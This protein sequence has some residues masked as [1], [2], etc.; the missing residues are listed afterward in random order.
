MLGPIKLNISSLAF[1]CWSPDGIAGN[2]RTARAQAHDS[3]LLPD[4]AIATMMVIIFIRRSSNC[5]QALSM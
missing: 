1:A 4:L 2:Q 5:Y 3:S